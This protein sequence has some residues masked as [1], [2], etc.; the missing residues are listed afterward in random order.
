MNKKQLLGMVCLVGALVSC[1]TKT[2]GQATVPAIDLTA[3]DTLVNP[4]EDFYRYVNGSWMANNPLPD[5]YSRYGSFDI[6]RDSSKNQIRAI[7]EDLQRG[8]AE[9]GSNEYRISTLYAQAMDSVTRNQLGATPIQG[10]LKAVEALGSK[11]EVV[12]FAAQRDQEFGSGT[13]FSSYVFTDQKNSTVNIFHLRQTGL[14]LGPK[15]YYLEDSETMKTIRAGY[16]TFIERIA[17]LAGYAEAD[18]KRIAS[19]TLKLETELAKMAYSPM[20]LRNPENNYNITEIA[21]YA[22]AHT[23]FD[24]AGYFS[25]RG[26]QITTANFAQIRFFDAF[27]SWFA[28]VDLAELKDL[29]LAKTL[30]GAASYLSDEFSDASFD[31]FGRIVSGR[32]EQKPRWE[33]S[34]GVVEGT[35]GEALSQVY[36]QRHFSP[37]AKERM[38]ELVGNLQK[39]LG[40]RVDQLTWMSAETKAKAKEK[41]NGFTVKIGYPDQ[42]KDYSALD[43]DASKTYYENVKSATRFEQQ[44]NLADLG[45]PVDRTKWLMNAHEVNAYYMPTTNEICFPAGIL[46]PPFFNVDADDAVN[47]GAIGVVIG[48]EMIHGFDDQGAKYD[49]HGNLNNWW[50]AE[51]ADKFKA[52][53]TRLD[54]QFSANE[55]LPGLFANG[56]LTLGENIADQGGLTIAYEALRLAKGLDAQ[57]KD[58]F[59]PAQRFF[60]AYARLWGQN[61]NEQEIHRLTKVDPHS[62]GELRVNQALKNIKEFHEAF[63]TKPGDKM[64]LAPEERIVVW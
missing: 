42:W 12:R 31:F 44:E 41:L 38:L 51:D 14:A 63:G 40:Q 11:A 29:L 59:T 34:L 53:T 57:P 46:Q 9:K 23:G 62:L 24:W 22:K 13:L 61:I 7:V 43:I 35:L 64:Y 32:K 26:L 50:T 48:H 36:V 17:T 30:R 5:A 20:E 15:D 56:S 58:G 3:M 47:Y 52:S 49:V 28:K 25:E 10:D 21:A 55:V 6:L 27:D 39:A 60:I 16:L 18:A 33:R 1:Q 54:G 37:K 19:N 4:T 45:K 8:K 2:Q